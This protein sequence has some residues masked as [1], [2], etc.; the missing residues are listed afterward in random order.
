MP[1]SECKVKKIISFDQYFGRFYEKNLLFFTILTIFA[2]TNDKFNY[3][4]QR[5]STQY[6]PI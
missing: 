4:N 2:P 1:K 5:N 3:Q 6:G